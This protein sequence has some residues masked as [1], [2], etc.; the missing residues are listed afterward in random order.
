MK[1]EWPY[2]SSDQVFIEPY[3]DVNMLQMALKKNK[4][5]QNI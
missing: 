1:H 2:F 5:K 4:I 3:S